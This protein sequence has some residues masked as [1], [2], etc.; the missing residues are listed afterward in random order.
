MD[1]ESPRSR[2]FGCWDGPG[3]TSSLV[4]LAGD[5][6]LA[7]DF[8]PGQDYCDFLMSIGFGE[9]VDQKTKDFW[10]SSIQ[11]N[12]SGDDGKRRI[13]MAAVTLA[14][15][16]GLHERLPYIRCPVLWLQ[17]GDY[18]IRSR[19]SCADRNKGTGDVVFSFENAAEEIKMFTNSAETR[20]VKLSKGVHF[21]SW[22][23]KEEVHQEL[24]GFLNKWGG[25]KKALL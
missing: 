7:H 24:L 10:S 21:L 8:E 9:T 16:D 17:V 1:S 23:H 18:G 11:Q 5:F 3:A 4:K 2:E 19:Y 22:T 20:L 13:C 12:Y 6:T 14:G 15:R 25:P